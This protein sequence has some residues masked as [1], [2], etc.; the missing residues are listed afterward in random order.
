VK[1]SEKI[2][3]IIKA[4][5][6][7]QGAI[8]NPAKTS[9]NP[10][11]KSKYSPLDEILTD[12]NRKLLSDNGIF[13]TQWEEGSTETISVHTMLAHVSGEFIQ[14]DPLTIKCDK[15]TAQ[16]AGSAITY[17]RRYTASSILGVAAEEDDDGN[18][19][20]GKATD[21]H[22]STAPDKFVDDNPFV[23]NMNTGISEKQVKRL[24][25]I[26]SK[27]GIDTAG[28]LRVLVHDYKKT[29]PESLT[30]EEYDAVCT[31]LE[32]KV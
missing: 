6:H 25:A 26:A 14:Y 16:G 20:E 13:F 17:A 9:I 8:K 29:S 24:F 23:Q 5:T 18:G 7:V 19:A 31:R 11:F 21:K 30:R 22:T 15:P 12:T 32:A 2:G 1:T 4:L 3:E 28:V 27:A 10:A